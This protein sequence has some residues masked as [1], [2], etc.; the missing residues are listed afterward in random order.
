MRIL[1]AICLIN[2]NKEMQAFRCCSMK[3]QI[4]SM[5][6]E[7]VNHV[8][9]IIST[10]SKCHSSFENGVRQRLIGPT[11]I[12]LPWSVHSRNVPCKSSNR[13]AF[14]SFFPALVSLSIVLRGF[15]LSRRDS[16][17]AVHCHR[18]WSRVWAKT[19]AWQSPAAMGN[20][21]AAGGS[22]SNA[23]MGAE[24]TLQGK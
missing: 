17:L 16:D 11:Q 9:Q 14:S 3:L 10:D 5:K 1:C 13:R 23:P 22:E 15:H 12:S 4:N 7:H 20:G 18:Y 24:Y 8:M 21:T 6:V 2:I 19:M